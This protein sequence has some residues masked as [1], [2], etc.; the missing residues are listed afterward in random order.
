[1]ALALEQAGH[2]EAARVR[3]EADASG[4]PWVLREQCRQTGQRKK[5]PNDRGTGNAENDVTRLP[6]PAVKGKLTQD[7]K[8]WPRAGED[9]QIQTS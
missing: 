6:V 7:E 1:M 8:V 2:P 9:D 4:E 5:R 3:R